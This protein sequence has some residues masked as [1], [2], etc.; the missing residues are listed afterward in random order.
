MSTAATR[1]R[2]RIERGSKRVRVYLAGSLVAD[3]IR[4][5]MVWEKP[6]YPSYYV[7]AEDVRMDLLSATDDVAHSPSRGDAIVHDVAVPAG[8][9]TTTAP[10]SARV[11]RESPVDELV[12]LV[13]F[14]FGSFDWFEEDEQIYVHP[15]DPYTRVD[16]LQSSRRVEVLVDGVTIAASSSPRLLFETGLPTRYYLA[17]TDIRMDLLRPS[18][19]ETACPYKGTASYYDVVL[20]DGTEHENLVWWYPAP[21][22]ESAAIA[23]YLAF[24]NEKVDIVVDGE[25][26]ERPRTV[27]S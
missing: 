26:Q 9:G 1:G 5:V 25:L 20:P 2:V 19:L 4:P 11:Y 21:V 13:A 7:P 10:A 16:I 15:R 27:F 12:G 18:E 24:Y 17:K 22:A 3:T 6:Y 8:E 14:R 23:G